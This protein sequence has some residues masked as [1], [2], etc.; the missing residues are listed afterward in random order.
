VV[1]YSK[2]IQK[3]KTVKDF[4][5]K[6]QEKI[7]GVISCPDRIIFKGYL[8][9]A[10]SE[11]M[12]GFLT[13]RGV[14]LKDFKE[15]VMHQSNRFRDHAIQIASKS[16][17]PYKYLYS[18][19]I[20][21]EEHA[22]NIAEKDGITEGLICVFPIVEPCQSFILRYGEKRPH[23]VSAQ[24]KCL[25]FYFYFIDRQMGLMHVRIQSWFPMTIQIYI[26]GHEWLARKLDKHGIKYER[27]DNA[28]L[29]I[30]DTKRAQRFADN[31]TRKRL[32]NFLS[33]FARRVNPLMKDSLGTMQYYWVI[34]QY[35][36]ATDIM[37]KD[38]ASLKELY[39]KLL[40]HATVCFSAEDIMSFLGRKPHGNFRGEVLS[41]SK[42]RVQGARI[43]HRMKGNWIKMY[44]KS[45]VVLRIETVINH[46]YEF[47][48]RR[49]GRRRGERMLGWFPM[50][51]GVV[52]FGRYA[53]VCLSANARYLGALS[54]VDDPSEAYHLLNKL[55]Q[56]VQFYGRRR[57]GMNP[58]RKDDLF[59][60]QIVLRGEHA[61]HGF[62]NSDLAKHLF[63]DQVDDPVLKR[64]RSATV[65]R[66]IQLLRA[67]GL[68]AKIPRSRL[69]RLSVEGIKLMTAAIHLA[70]YYMPRQILA[71]AA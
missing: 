53:E 5:K 2:P 69:Y 26:N 63:P 43:K 30:E 46:P 17:R 44:D 34:D 39:E 62:R 65:T 57:R 47:K 71:N 54:V 9:I 11:G 67:H 20:R 6:H 23:L 33:A 61:I 8:P 32:P 36:Y 22:K 16:G 49:W 35:E 68:I 24:R 64:R 21:K 12:D 40:E 70:H 51:K 55:C 3:D 14:L 28:F 31:F 52:N 59:L 58:L 19:G 13:S 4:I 66:L 1:D 18:S 50:A 60:F 37:F 27:V 10:H 45:G 48:V 56:P 25:C 41:Y 29:W 42:K 15:F 38:L 7:A